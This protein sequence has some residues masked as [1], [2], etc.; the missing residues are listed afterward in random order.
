VQPPHPSAIIWIWPVILHTGK[1]N[2]L[3]NS[4]QVAA[5]RPGV[6]TMHPVAEL[7]LKHVQSKNTTEVVTPQQ[8]TMHD[9]DDVWHLPG[10]CIACVQPEESY[11]AIPVL[12]YQDSTQ[13]MQSNPLV[14][15][16][17][18]KFNQKIHST[19]RC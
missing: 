15:Y 14:M 2:A 12:W 13:V 7:H 10:I 4:T 11:N 8:H 1:L 17:C 19:H 5:C 9:A 3:A 16:A 6:Q 18:P